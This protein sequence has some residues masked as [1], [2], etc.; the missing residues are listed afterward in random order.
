MK[1]EKV[2]TGLRIPQTRYE[3]LKTLSERAGVSI[4]AAILMLIDVGMQA[5]SFGEEAAFHS[6]AHNPLHTFL[7]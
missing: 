5:L 2:Q 7:Q 4:N 6:E 1:D 3:E